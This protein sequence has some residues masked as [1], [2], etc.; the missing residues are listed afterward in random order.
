MDPMGGADAYLCDGDGDVYF[1]SPLAGGGYGRQ[2]TDPDCGYFVQRT[3]P[4]GT[5][6]YVHR[7]QVYMPNAK[8]R[9]RLGTLT[10]ILAVAFGGARA[11]LDLMAAYAQEVANRNQALEEL[12]SVYGMCLATLSGLDQTNQ[13]AASTFPYTFVSTL[14]LHGLLEDGEEFITDVR[15]RPVHGEICPVYAALTGLKKIQSIYDTKFDDGNTIKLELRKDGDYDDVSKWSNAKNYSN[16]TIPS[17]FDDESKWVTGFDQNDELPL[18]KIPEFLSLHKKDVDSVKGPRLPKPNIKYWTVSLAD[19][20]RSNNVAFYGTS[21][22][23][24]AITRNSVSFAKSDDV[25]L[26]DAGVLWCHDTYYVTVLKFDTQ[27]FAIKSSALDIIEKKM[28]IFLPQNELRSAMDA[29]RAD[30]D[31]QNSAMQVPVSYLSTANNNMQA[32][33]SLATGLI[34]ELMG[35][36]SKIAKNVRL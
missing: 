33:F 29:I 9:E 8:G 30:M 35:Q 20:T 18:E 22:D 19:I 2:T 36:L 31:R 11:Q 26:V 6:N 3:M 25:P 7:S 16:R 5:I 10:L 1:F 27:Q 17:K 14:V 12:R 24:S 4:D 21:S 13:W 28:S 34:Q 23:A 32:V 15:L